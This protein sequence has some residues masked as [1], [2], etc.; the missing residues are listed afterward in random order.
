MVEG[1]CTLFAGSKSDRG[2]GR[3]KV[4]G[5]LVL[6]HRLAYAK[7]HGLDVH[8]LGG[9]VMHLCDTPAC[10]NP[11]HLELATQR[12]NMLDML[13]KGRANSARGEATNRNKITEQQAREIKYGSSTI[14]EASAQYGICKTQ[15]SR[16][17]RGLK[18]SHL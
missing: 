4:G 14:A 13:S 3:V 5:K 8:S 9:V 15:V 12:K 18:W 10:I 2:Y 7:H 6:A 11:H 17:R 16:I 1:P